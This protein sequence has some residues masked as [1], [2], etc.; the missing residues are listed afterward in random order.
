MVF[1]ES[2]VADEVWAGVAPRALAGEALLI[3]LATSS[4]LSWWRP[5]QPGTA[6]AHPET[7]VMM[8]H[9]RSGRRCRAVARP[10]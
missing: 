9:D 2:R 6:S 5:T 7:V 3:V 8:M 4:T 10:I 1:R